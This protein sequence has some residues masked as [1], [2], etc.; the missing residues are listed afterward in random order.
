MK[1]LY[2]SCSHVLAISTDRV[3]MSESSE[4]ELS[5]WEKI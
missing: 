5:G 3:I 1:S 2:S 4:E